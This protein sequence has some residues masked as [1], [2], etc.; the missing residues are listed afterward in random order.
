MPL[1]LAST[2][3]DF[4][5]RFAAFVE[6]GRETASDVSQAVAAIIAD[7]RT[8]GDAAVFELTKRFDRVDADAATLRFTADEIAAARGK[9][10]PELRA[11]L[12]LAADRVRAFHSE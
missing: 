3:T 12:E 9:I 2:D 5:A 8:R 7:V 1:R 11:A 4:A 6:V 10:A